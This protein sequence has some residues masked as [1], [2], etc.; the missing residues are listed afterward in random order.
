MTSRIDPKLFPDKAHPTTCALN[1]EAYKMCH[2]LICH[3]LGY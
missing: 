2:A 1:L 3:R